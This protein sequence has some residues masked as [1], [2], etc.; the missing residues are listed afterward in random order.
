[1]FKMNDETGEQKTRQGDW[2]SFKVDGIDADWDVFYSVY[3]IETR[4]ILLEVQSEKENGVDIITVL[5]SDCDKLTVEDGK[6]SATYGWNIKRCKGEIEDTVIVIGKSVDD[7]NK[8]I[9]LPKTTEG[10]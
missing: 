4:E 6:K 10:E 5:P 7:I 2:Y 9:V 1:M 3:N 8:I